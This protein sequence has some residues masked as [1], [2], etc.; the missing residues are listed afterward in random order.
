[1]RT[2]FWLA[3][4]CVALSFPGGLEA[5]Q[6]NPPEA[7][8]LSDFSTRY[9]LDAGEE[10]KIYRMRLTAEIFRNI[11]LSFERDLA[12]FDAGGNPLPFMVRDADSSFYAETAPAGG[13][14]GTES[15]RDFAIPLF[16]LPRA[17]GP[18]TTLMDVTIK[19]DDDGQVMEIRKKSGPDAGGSGGRFLLD[20]SR[21]ENLSLLAERAASCR[22]DMPLSGEGMT[23]ID[24]YASE[25]LRDWRK[26][27]SR[28]PLV[29]LRRGEESVTSR[30]VELDPA[31]VARYLMLEIDGQGTLPDNV[32]LSV[33]EKGR[34]GEPE[35]DS[36]AFEGVTDENRA[37]VL[38]DTGGAFPASGVNFVLRDP[39]LYA[40]SVSS[41]GKNDTAWQKHGNDMKLSFIKNDNAESRNAPM[42]VDAPDRR[43]W[44]LAPRDG[45]PS[46]PPR[47]LLFWEPK[48][49]VFMAQGS[50]PYILA[51]GSDRD[52]PGLARPDLLR[53]VLGG[54]D[55]RTVQETRVAEVL[56][57][58]DAPRDPPPPLEDDGEA[59]R[60][61]LRYL[62][63]AILAGAAL[64]MSW[65]AWNLLRK[66]GSA[67]SSE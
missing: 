60:R 39:G 32:V 9:R 11:A 4:A 38:Y 29:H 51:C 50:P 40:V 12:V 14:S 24:V 18:A 34:N 1:M 15:P 31:L 54:V 62:V 53:G 20:L 41:R 35:M 33:T 49:L 7:L 44:L 6:P 30:V 28:E 5:A 59:D 22:L 25:N 21:V 23:Y 2:I 67:S 36:A 19:T 16:P 66:S 26:I 17:E 55:A 8:R 42:R 65:M 63:W 27:A 46:P 45:M 58:R 47:M 57:G 48:E 64:L 52:A 56:A 10:G 13:A 37:G 3:A 43:Y 61:W